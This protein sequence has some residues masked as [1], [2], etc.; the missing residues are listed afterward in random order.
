[1]TS[2]DQT[3]TQGDADA[4]RL[5]VVVIGASL[6]GLFA[7][8]A[9]ADAGCRVTV[10][11]RDLLP[12]RPQSRPGVPQGDQPHVFLYRGLLAAEELLPG[13]DAELVTAGAVPI[14]TGRLPWLAEYGWSPIG[15]HGYRILS[16]TRP[17]LE[18]IVRRRVAATD[19]V[20]IRGGVQVDGL[21]RRLAGWVLHSRDAAPIEAD[22]VIDA[23]GR[24][25][26]LDRWLDVLGVP[27]ARVSRI[28]A[29]VGYAT[30]L[31]RG[32]PGT[33]VVVLA[34]VEHA[35]GGLVLPVEGD[36]W[37]VG[38]VGIGDDR[39]PRDA[40]GF[41]AYLRGLRD[42]AL[43]DQ[44][45]GWEPLGDV[46]V[47]RQTANVR[48][49]YEELEQWPARLLVLGDAFCAFDP[50]YGHG[51]TVAARQAVELR[52]QVAGLT[53]A[54]ET[55][56]LQRRLAEVVELP[57]AI[58]AGQDLRFPTSQGRQTRRQ[59][60]ISNWGRQVGHLA[61]CGNARAAAVLSRM[62]HLMGA[63]LEIFHPALIGA[64]ALARVRGFP[65]GNPRPAMLPDPR[66]GSRDAP[67]GAGAAAPG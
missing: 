57:W 3:S 29:G 63:P 4:G 35:R 51:I 2:A 24:T 20:A 41:L 37:Q 52:G 32:G 6:A 28:D 45:Q 13:L 39:P 46:A 66:P 34:T 8:V 67:G 50:I 60:L 42:P 40:D 16:L 54:A 18:Q 1:M 25:S 56:R 21:Q 11:D 23:S 36:R 61:S 22:L 9:A 27:A 12:D 10:L 7:A 53:T 59:A 44:V 49:H 47:H 33:P 19:R 55:R 43:A 30:R 38:V 62:Y 15:D 48:H 5:H 14:D 65:A 64:V 31:Y 26:R 58:A 17:L